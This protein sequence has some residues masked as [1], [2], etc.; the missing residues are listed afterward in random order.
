GGVAGGPIAGQHE[1]QRRRG[2]IRFVGQGGRLRAA[3]RQRRE[4]SC[5]H[6]PDGGGNAEAAELSRA[7]DCL[8]RR[9]PLR[10]R[11]ARKQP[12][13]RTARAREL[14]ILRLPH[15]GRGVRRWLPERAGE[16]D[17]QLAE[18]A[19]VLR[20]RGKSDRRAMKRAESEELRF[21]HATSGNWKRGTPPLAGGLSW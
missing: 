11:Q 2:A 15:G 6:H 10:L 17:D 21:A 1:P 13:R 19:G 9:R 8:Q 18:K 12:A 14:G 20:A 4:G 5:T 3:A 16:L 7:A